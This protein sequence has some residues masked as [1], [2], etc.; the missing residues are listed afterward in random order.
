MCI[1]FALRRESAH[2]TAA[3]DCETIYKACNLIKSVS[4]LANEAILKVAK[5]SRKTILII[6]F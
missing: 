4:Y 6:D 2:L 3:K 5:A 1:Q